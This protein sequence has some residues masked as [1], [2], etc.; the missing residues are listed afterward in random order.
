MLKAF[1]DIS[2]SGKNVHTLQ[3]S[4]AG[5]TRLVRIASKA[6]HHR[7]C[8]KSGVEDVFTAYLM[9]GHGQKNHLVDYIGNRANI[10]FEGAAALYYHLDHILSFLSMLDHKN[11]LLLAV[12]EDAQEMIYKAELRAL[13]LFH[14]LVTKPFWD[15][16]KQAP[17]IFSMNQPLH[18]LQQK[19]V[20][21]KEDARPMLSGESPFEVDLSADPIS[22]Q[23]LEETPADLE[24]MTIQALELSS[25]AMLLILQRQCKDQLPGGKYWEP[26]PRLAAAFANVPST[27]LIGE[28][29]FAQL[30]MLVRQK[31]A[32]RVST[33]ETIVM[34]TNN[35]TPEWL[36]SLSE[37]DRAKY[38]A[39]ARQRS[40]DVLDRYNKRKKS[41][42]AQKWESLQ[43][44]QQ[45]KK[46]VAE[47]KMQSS[48]SLVNEVSAL[49][50][51][52]TSVDS[53]N[54]HVSELE[55]SN[56]D[57]YIRRAIHTQLTF[58]Q[59]VLKC[60]G[61]SKA[62]FQLSHQQHQHSKAEM[63]KNLQEVILHHKLEPQSDPHVL[64][65]SQPSETSGLQ[66]VSEDDRAGSFEEQKRKLVEKIDGEK[67]KRSAQSSRLYLQMYL[68]DPKLLIGKD[69]EHLFI[70]D[71]QKNVDKRPCNWYMFP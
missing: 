54:S 24:C 59:K 13:G 39:I 34:W 68:D 56:G 3:T 70:V 8:D 45:K 6:F 60:K 32:A 67:K 35:K 12:E 26:S 51:L 21:W 52:W 36:E 65:A 48:A 29:D 66:Y 2:K 25:C 61:P 63:T 40:S 58:L 22:T 16:V 30:D 28:R 41:L 38:M 37:E 46:D 31:P 49:G 71:Q 69:V 44:S 20:E 7:G 4:E 23:L 53:I 10:L 55:K 17:D 19:L 42:M 11:N 18:Q 47:K 1:E 15:L 57:E 27:N 14:V 43:Q 9:N 5:V 50:G 33:L 62:H 64:I